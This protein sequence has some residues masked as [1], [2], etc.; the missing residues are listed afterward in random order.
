MCRAFMISCFFSVH[1]AILAARS[2]VFAAMFDHNSEEAQNSRVQ[3]DD[4]DPDV[5]FSYLFSFRTFFS[6]LTLIRAFHL[7]FFMLVVAFCGRPPDAIIHMYAFQRFFI[8]S[9]KMQIT[10]IKNLE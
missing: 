1:K 9:V 5:V 3:I 2:P 6:I 10:F 8:H 4:V 7:F